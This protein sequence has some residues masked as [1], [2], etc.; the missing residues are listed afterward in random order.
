MTA[1]TEPQNKTEKPLLRSS[2]EEKDTWDISKMF[3]TTEAWKEAFLALSL[4][5]DS[6]IAPQKYTLSDPDSVQSLLENLFA[7]QRT[8]EKLYVYAHLAHDQDITHQESSEN[9]KS[10]TLFYTRFCEEISWIRPSLV[11]LS[12]EIIEKLRSAPQLSAYK[13]YLENI[14]RAA[15][16]TGTEREEAIIAA[17][18][19]ALDATMKTF[20]SL[21]DSEIP[22]G[23][24]TDSKGET[25]PI[26]HAL[27]SLYMQSTDRE[28]RR[29]TYVSQRERYLNYK[30]TFSNLLFGRV[31]AHW[32]LAKASKFSSCIESALFTNNIPVDV[33]TNLLQTVKSNTEITSRYYKIKKKALCLETFFAYDIY[34]PISESVQTKYDY[35][36]AVSLTLEALA[37]LGEDY[38]DKLH[39]GLTTNRWVD[40]Y[41]NLNKRSG[42]YSSGCYDSM[43]YILL[44]YT[45]TVYD[46]SVLAHEAG[47]SMHTLYSV[48]NQPY[49][50]AQYPIFLAEIASTLN[51]MLLMQHLIKK[52]KSKEEKISLITRTLDTIFATLVRQTMFADFEYQIH[53]SV[54]KGMPLTADFLNSI[55]ENLLKEYYGDGVCWPEDAA[56]EWARIPHFYYNFYV[57]QYATG[58]IASL[59]FAER[60]LSNEAGALNDYL[61]FLKSGGSDFPLNILK[62]AGLDMS[63]PEPSRKAFSFISKL[64]DELEHLL[65]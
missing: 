10:V 25:H 53:S 13:F 44:N 36:E 5:Q 16:H 3:P 39:H 62:N 4:D 56:I 11:N 29:S 65:A 19:S 15:E 41:E 60:I 24:A 2:V 51:E 54:E 52:A 34:A 1:A 9:Y 12:P 55:Y 43:P 21:N 14:F 63:S 8:V 7:R 37:P 30:H 20:S 31:N 23:Q 64:L 57:Y 33:Y 28:L 6:V 45:G 46:V 22:F 58:I 61:T 48:L 49:Q 17:S 27:A 18:A 50:N 32:F 38:L 26:S 35:E 59:S 42:A 47:H 40:K